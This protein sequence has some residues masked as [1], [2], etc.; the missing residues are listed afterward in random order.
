MTWPPVFLVF[1]I[2]GPRRRFGCWLP[3]VLIWLPALI[4]ALALSPL[5]AV[6]SILLWPSGY[7]RT[8]LRAGPAF[9]SLFSA[10]RGL[11]VDVR[12]K[13]ETVYISFS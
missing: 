5:I 3:F 8:V 4:L 6:L 9:Y 1:R 13:R 2:G 10:L 12:G 11:K 7:G